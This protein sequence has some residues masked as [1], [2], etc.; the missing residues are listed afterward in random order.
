VT[1]RT[2]TF[3]I[4]IVMS[5]DRYP[6]G[7]SGR[8]FAPPCGS[9]ARRDKAVKPHARVP[10]SVIKA[11]GPL[12][13]LSTIAVDTGTKFPSRVE[14]HGQARYDAASALSSPLVRGQQDK[15]GISPMSLDAMDASPQSSL[16]IAHGKPQGGQSWRG[17]LAMPERRSGYRL[18]ITAEPLRDADAQHGHARAGL[19]TVARD[20]LFR[21]AIVGSDAL[22]SVLAIV[23]ALEVGS[24]YRLRLGFLLVVPLTV[25]LSKV[26]GLYDRDELVIRKSTLDEFPKLLNLAT[27]VAMLAWLSRHFFVLGAPS[28]WPLLKLW[29]ALLI[30]IVIGRALGRKLAGRIAP[31]ERC[32]F[33]GDINTAKQVQTKLSH[34]ENSE[35]VGAAAGNQLTLADEAIQDLVRRFSLN[36]LIIQSGSGLTEDRTID[37]VRSAKA[38]G[39]HVTICPG[40]L[41]VVGSSVVFDEVWGLPLLGVPRFGLS[42]SSAMLKRALD[43][44]GASL[45]LILC[46]P[47]FA[48]I[49]V[50]IKLDSE[51]PVL[52]RQTRI[53]RGGEPFQILKF[54]TMVVDAE[55]RKADLQAHNENVGLFKIGDDPRVT[56]V[57]RRLRKS[58]L[59]EFPQLFNVLC[60]QMSLVG[61]RP[62]VVDEDELIQGLDRRRL[63]I[64]PGMTGQWQT[65]GAIRVP[66]QEM[67]KL[68][69]MYVAN[70]SLWNDIKILLRTAV[71]VVGGRG[72]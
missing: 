23:F 37:L 53:G 35:L 8:T 47:I 31:A 68:D 58:S 71:V 70:W 25:L 22:A 50:L 67:T 72:V 40:V 46:A 10:A 55:Q 65:L 49:A 32:F 20:K 21:R 27:L 39:V 34:S 4:W 38:A 62:L 36:R 15:G 17:R 19:Q 5:H 64:T 52:F 16:G 12:A 43:V 51:G 6:Q 26:Q 48:V 18:E 11:V 13:S 66:I 63:A 56:R 60:G 1:G 14:G 30:F 69:Y 54:R 61:P 59:D 57:G 41:A 44:L 28:S 45:G 29:V 42:R 24:S 9:E 33:F 3:A 2:D 7:Q